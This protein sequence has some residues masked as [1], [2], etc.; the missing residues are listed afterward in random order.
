MIRVP[1][2]I[3][4]LWKKQRINHMHEG[5]I[6]RIV[7]KINARPNIPQGVYSN[8][9]VIEWSGFFLIFSKHYLWRS[10]IVLFLSRPRIKEID[11]YFLVRVFFGV[12][13]FWITRYLFVCV[14]LVVVEPNN[15]DFVEYFIKLSLNIFN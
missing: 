10:T 12:I 11:W 8:L 5:V 4:S 9:Q 6:Q 15:E 13:R 1:I 7:I 2:Q 14:S 3:I